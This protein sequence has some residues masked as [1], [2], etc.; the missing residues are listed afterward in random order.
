MARPLKQV[1]EKIISR[2]AK[3]GCTTEEIASVA[4]CSKDTLERRFAAIIQKGR[5]DMR[6]SLRRIQWRMAE[7]GN[8]VMAIWLGKQHLEQREPLTRLALTVDDADK[9]IDDAVAKHNL[10]KPESFAG[11]PLVESEM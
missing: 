7:K 3:I 11:E 8:V 1:D 5:A 10:P 4:G 6:M 9:A 2:L